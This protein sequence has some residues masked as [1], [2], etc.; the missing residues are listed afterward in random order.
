MRI[1]IFH[2][3]L[4]RLKLSPKQISKA[5]AF[6]AIEYERQESIT[7]DKLHELIQ[8]ENYGRVQCKQKKT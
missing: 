4:G 3:L 5:L 8:K 7:P 6:F 1:D 2:K